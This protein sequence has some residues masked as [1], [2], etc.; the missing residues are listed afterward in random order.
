MNGALGGKPT[1]ENQNG[2][3]YFEALKVGDLNVPGPA[4]IYVFLDEHADS[5]DDMQF[6]LNPGYAPNAEKWRNFPASYHNGAGSL[7]FADGHSEIHKWH[8]AKIYSTVQPVAMVQYPQ[9]SEP[10][11][12][13]TFSGNVDYEWLDDRMP[14]HP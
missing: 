12:A 6:M 8:N 11:A 1:F 3:N 9:G 14:Y 2:R 13:P 4:N 10:W 7:S 5:I